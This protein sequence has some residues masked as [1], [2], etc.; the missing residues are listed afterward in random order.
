MQQWY[1]AV[2]SAAEDAA[3]G[4]AEDAVGKYRPVRP[5]VPWA[6]YYKDQNKSN[7]FLPVYGIFALAELLD[8]AFLLM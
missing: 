6:Y 7:S 4:A 8:W 1:I 2:G 3:E 5:S